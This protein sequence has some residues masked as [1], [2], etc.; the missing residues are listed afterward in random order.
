MRFA[1]R[2]APPLFQ[3]LSLSAPAGEI[4]ALV[5]KSGCGKSTVLRLVAGLLRASGGS[6]TAPPGE[7]AFVFQ[8][9]TLLPWRTVA[10]NVALPLELRGAPDGATR[11]E[12]ALARVGL[13]QAAGL[14]PRQLSG[15][16][17][18]RASLARAL[19]TQPA[20]MLMDEPFSAL[21]PLTRK[22]LQQE[23]LRLWRER[24]FTVLMVS[25]DIDEAVLLADQIVVL[26]GSPA[27]VKLKLM[28]DLERPRGPELLH[29]PRLGRLAAQVEE[30]L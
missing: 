19:V 6:V 4:T 24:R 13:S 5:G 28:V 22:G 30:A 3:G 16:M 20:L 10:E 2:G 7:R 18:M 8:S 9:P 26:G 15:G 17:R 21:D 1:W 27:E 29:D 25:H 11:V 14:L 12:D 23:F